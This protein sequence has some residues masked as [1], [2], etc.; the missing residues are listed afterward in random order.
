MRASVIFSGIQPSGSIHLGNYLGAIRQWLAPAASLPPGHAC[1]CSLFS[2]VDLHALTVPGRGGAALRRSTL[3]VSASLLA[4]GL[5]PSPTLRL[6]PQSAVREHTEL[7]WLLAC[8]TPLGKLQRMTQYKQKGR[9]QEGSSNLGLLAYP[10]LQAADIL[11]YRATH[12]PVGEDQQQHLELARE[13]AEAANAAWGAGAQQAQ[14]A[15]QAQAQQLF[16]LPA[17]LT[18]PL[19]A[20]VMSLKDGRV[21]MSKSDPDDASR[22]NMD[23]SSEAIAAKVRGAKT[24][25]TVGFAPLDAAARPEKANLVGILAAL[26]GQSPEAVAQQYAGASAVAFKAELTEALVGTV[27]PIRQELQRLRGDLGAVEAVL[28]EGADAARGMAQD[29]MA[30]VRAASGL[31]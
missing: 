10:V 8:Q 16:P 21:K 23:D 29:T 17:T 25:S 9:G 15:Q 20:R 27:A 13:V 11:L 2:V 24:D 3:E 19:G 7:A 18:L 30:A 22:I 1:A 12:V 14:Q 26:R 4:C 31:Y 5:A 28:R 6:F